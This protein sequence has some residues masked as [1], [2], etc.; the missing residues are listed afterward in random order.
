MGLKLRKFRK[1]H[2]KIGLFSFSGRGKFINLQNPAGEN[3]YVALTHFRPDICICKMYIY[4]MIILG[5]E[6]Q[7]ILKI[8]PV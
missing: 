5:L 2:D 1:I 4:I 8:F 6:R 3:L 7:F